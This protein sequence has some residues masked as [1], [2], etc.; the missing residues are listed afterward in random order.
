ME[1]QFKG[2]MVSGPQP[3]PLS[4]YFLTSHHNLHCQEHS[5]SKGLLM[6]PNEMQKPQAL[7]FIFHL[8][9]SLHLNLGLFNRRTYPFKS[10]L[11]KPNKIAM[12][13]ARLLHPPHL[14]QDGACEQAF[15][16]PATLRMTWPCPPMLTGVVRKD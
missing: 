13:E 5:S 6:F 9:L 11:T 16:G 12:S 4:W 7:K 15:S 14:A 2:A 3:V 8:K 10:F 1:L